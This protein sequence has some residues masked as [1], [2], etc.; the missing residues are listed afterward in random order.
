MSVA[1]EAR[2]RQLDRQVG[3]CGALEEL[4]WLGVDR[5]VHT[6]AE[7]GDVPARPRQALFDFRGWGVDT[8]RVMFATM[9]G[10]VRTTSETTPL[11][12]LPLT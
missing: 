7:P 11:A 12:T 6:Q 10:I 3:G 4:G 9:P 1:N 8:A 2:S 5:R